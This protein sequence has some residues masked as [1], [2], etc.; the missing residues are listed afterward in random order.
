[1]GRCHCLRGVSADRRGR[2]VFAVEEHGRDRND[3][4]GGTHERGDA[5]SYGKHGEGPV[6]LG[7]VDRHGFE[8]RK[9]ACTPLVAG[10]RAE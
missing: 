7:S 4:T 9:P 1:M 8:L 2:G 10:H 6:H 5:R 3:E